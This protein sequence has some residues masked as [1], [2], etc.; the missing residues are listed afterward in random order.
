[1]ADIDAT[2]DAFREC[3][4]I[5]GYIFNKELKSPLLEK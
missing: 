1:L 5:I 2:V 4:A 3:F